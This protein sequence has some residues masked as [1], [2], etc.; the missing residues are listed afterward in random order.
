MTPLG[1][2]LL[3]HVNARARC[4]QTSGRPLRPR[5]QSLPVASL[6]GRDSDP[7]PKPLAPDPS[8]FQPVTHEEAIKAC[9]ERSRRVAGATKA[10]D[11]ADGSQLAAYSRRLSDS[12]S[13]RSAASPWPS[14]PPALALAGFSFLR[15]RSSILNLL[16]SILSPQFLRPLSFSHRHR[17]CRA[18]S[19]HRLRILA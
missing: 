19:G 18:Q 4:R 6:L 16:L 8:C 5:P 17:L 9:P 15:P 3:K 14:S 10:T 7:N 11:H 13:G 1:H 2:I 12:D